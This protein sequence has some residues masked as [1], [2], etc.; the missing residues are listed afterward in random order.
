LLVLTEVLALPA[1]GAA[2]AE[3]GEPG[4]EVEESG[5]AAGELQPARAI[6]K[7]SRPA[8]R[9]KAVAFEASWLQPYF[10]GAIL[11]RAATAFR[12]EQWS[13]AEA[14]LMKGIAR[15]GAGAS[16]ADERHAARFLL[17]LAR[18]NQSRWAEAAAG[19]EALY[20]EYPRLAPYH[21]YNAA[22]CLLRAGRSED[23]LAWTDKVDEG[24]VL[25][26]ET[27]LV[28]IDA[29]RALGR[30]DEAARTSA[31][32][33]IRFPNGPRRAETM[34]EEAQALERLGAGP[35]HAAA[36]SKDGGGGQP[37]APPGRPGPAATTPAPEE[38][39]PQTRIVGLY[40]RV[41]ADAPLE[42]WSD[43]A[44]E[45]LQSLA[46]RGGSG[47]S[48]M[49][50]THSA[51]E[52]LARGMVYFDRN[53][54]PES[55]TAFAN[56]LTAEGLTL[57]LECQARYYRAQSVW[58]QRQRPRAAPLFDEAEAA[59]ARVGNRDLRAK[60]LYQGAR[61]W[62]NA[63][64]RASAEKRYALIEAEHADHSYADDA[65]LRLAEL[66]H[67]A[68]EED[69]AIA[70]LKVIPEKYPKG[71]LLGEALWRLA[72][73][74]WKREQWDEAERWLDEN[75]AR[76][77]HED[78][79][80]AEGR[81]LY[82]KAR[83]LEKKHDR[84]GSLR[85]Y[86]RAIRE[87]PLSVYALLSFAR[88]GESAPRTRAGLIQ[89]LHKTNGHR[90]PAA[91]HF[92]PRPLFGEAGFR[93]AVDL[94]RMGQGGDARRELSRL[95]LQTAGEKHDK[96]SQGSSDDRARVSGKAEENELLWIAAVLLDRAGVWS[97]AASIPRY[98]LTSYRLAYPEGLG[99]AKWRLAYPRA[100]PEL[101]TRNARANQIPEALQWA[102]MR[103]ES[104]FSP[105]IESFA[106]AVGL[107]Q[108]LVKTA[109]R[110]SNGARV[111]RESLMDPG[112]NLEYGARFLGFLWGHFLKAA[113]LAIAAYNAG[114]AA[115]DR[116]LAERGNLSMDEFME[117]VP[118]D[119][120]RNYTKRVLASYLTYAW[121]YSDRTPV[122]P[123]PA[124]ARPR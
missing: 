23:A 38:V 80:Y 100:F 41:W 58:K 95:G 1:P 108:M 12:Q 78:V 102:I 36:R 32:Y 24:S 17:A 88:L 26:A 118:Y 113:P 7:A 93:R 90:E 77:P 52:W 109:S 46:R 65:R 16:A 3:E 62:A 94:G 82:W 89:A 55:E 99:E 33:L 20:H 104:A 84:P 116:W 103:E 85:L 98:T 18:A 91:F 11:H 117:E 111:T 53:R 87:Y 73:S 101:V 59:C 13:T 120:T 25:E 97:A 123:V 40:R 66:A 69:K 76:I 72:Y 5:A 54:N 37:T 10:A 44:E 4:R 75:L 96:A 21:A 50:V 74:A 79:W 61:S 47:E 67:D 49:V 30:W 86:E 29:Y 9:E 31:D 124:A 121:L 27:T 8:R 92:A 39:E 112:K 51:E 122:P 22:R 114:E 56:A 110:F 63:G 6:T 106:N 64:D 14:G 70:I 115:V 60:S 119:E 107:T 42:A 2:R 43:R 57:E 19:F 28:R 83:V 34:Y 71:D 81:A 45:R 68:G 48:G 105:R 35:G 15:L